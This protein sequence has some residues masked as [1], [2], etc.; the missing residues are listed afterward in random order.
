ML[1]LIS[2]SLL[3]SIKNLKTQ[4][5]KGQMILLK[6]FIICKG[7]IYTLHHSLGLCMKIKKSLFLITSLI[8]AY[9]TFLIYILNV[10]I[11]IRN[12]LLLLLVLLLSIYLSDYINEIATKEGVQV[13]CIIQSPINN[14]VKEH[15]KV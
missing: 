9:N 3:I 10:L 1:M 15:F 13:Q 7:Q 8:K 6:I 14:L 12:T 5:M 4:L 2:S 11:I